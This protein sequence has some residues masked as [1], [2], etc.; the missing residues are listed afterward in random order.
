MGIFC[1]WKKNIFCWKFLEI[2]S[3]SL[4]SEDSESDLVDPEIDLSTNSS[5]GGF[6]ISSQEEEKCEEFLAYLYK[7]L[8]TGIQWKK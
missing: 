1:V 5:P 3:I 6:A 4:L 2:D 8:K 7:Y